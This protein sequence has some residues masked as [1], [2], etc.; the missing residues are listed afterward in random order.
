[1]STQLNTCS[2]F[3]YFI[4]NAPTP[5][6][7]STQS[8]L[9]LGT[10][11]VKPMDSVAPCGNAGSVPFDC[12]DFSGCANAA[13]AS[14]EIIEVVNS[15]LIEAGYTI[16]NTGFNFTTATQTTYVPNQKFEVI[17]KSYC[18]TSDGK[19]ISDF[20]RL[21]VYLN[22]QC[23]SAEI[24][25]TCNPCDGKWV[26]ATDITDTAAG[27]TGNTAQGASTKS[28]DCVDAVVYAI[29]SGGYDITV[30]ENVS[31]NSGTG[32]ITYDLI[33]Q[34]TIPETTTITYTA[35]VCGVTSTAT[36]TLDI[37]LCAN[38]TCAACEF[39]DPYD[40][41]CD[42]YPAK[43]VTFTDISPSTLT[44]GEAIDTS[45]VITYTEE[46]DAALPADVVFTYDVVECGV[47]ETKTQTIT[48]ACPTSCC[49]CPVL[50]Q[51]S[52]SSSSSSTCENCEE[53]IYSPPENSE[54]DV[55][56]PTC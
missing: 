7:T 28:T 50:S 37:N 11:T 49:D 4:P 47:T 1:M 6:C 19:I 56:G 53:G 31:I 3:S 52:S 41:S 38:V 34:D 2:C 44:T 33:D 25:S 23:D 8:C 16:S 5:T 43:T 35:T 48:V 54:F 55:D 9:K 46:C 10:I 40:G 39:C 22:D 36:A 27:S 21:V 12:F 15:D 13:N 20:G 42:P 29:P 30:L 18:T 45:E 26:K 14:F 32:E 51:S 17:F 24:N